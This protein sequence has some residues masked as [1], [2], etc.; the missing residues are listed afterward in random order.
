QCV[1]HEG[2]ACA[3]DHGFAAGGGDGIIGFPGADIRF[4]RPGIG[5][6]PGMDGIIGMPPGGPIFIGGNAPGG[7]FFGRVLAFF[8]SSAVG[9][10]ERNCRSLAGFHCAVIRTVTF[11]R[12]GVGVC[13]STATLEKNPESM[14][15]DRNPTTCVPSFMEPR[16]ARSPRRFI[17]TE[18]SLLPG[19]TAFAS[20]NSA[21]R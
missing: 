6:P 8:S 12:S 11:C 21:S 5:P 7:G 18:S 20:R 15:F 9:P 13:S 19:G 14:S 2:S 1:F 4:P 17:E 3:W 16:K 10:I